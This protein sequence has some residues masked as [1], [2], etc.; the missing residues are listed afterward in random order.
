MKR[1]KHTLSHYNMRTF[2]LGELVPVQCVPV[3]PGDTAQGWNS[4]IFRLSP[5]NTP[6]MHPVDVRLHTWFV[7]NR[8]IDDGWED[9]ITGGN[10]GTGGSLPTFNMTSGKKTLMT[11]LGVP[12]VAVG[13]TLN[14]LPLYACNKII[15][16]RYLDQDAETQR[17][18]ADGSVPFCAWEKDYFTTARPWTQR[19][20]DVTLPVGDSAP[21]IGEAI[22]TGTLD[23]LVQDGA[24]GTIR[25]VTGDPAALGATSAN[26]HQLVADLANAVSPTVNDWRAAFSLQRYQEAR[27]RYGA[28]FTEYLRYLGIT[29]S[30]ARLQEPEYLGGGNARVNFSEVLQTSPNAS[31]GTTGDDGV[32]DLY[33]HGIAGI[34]TRRWRKWF[35]EHGY[36][37]TMCS[38]RPKALYVNGVHR[39]FLKTTKEDYFQKELANLGQQ[40]IY[41]QELHGG[42]TAG[43]VFGY[44]DRYDEYRYHPSSIAQDFRDT[45]NSWHMGRDLDSNPTLNADFV[46]CDP[47]GRIFQV[48]PA[49]ADSVWMSMNNHLV[50]RRMVPKRAKPRII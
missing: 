13:E 9:F 4:G 50:I 11:Y 37:I 44:Q 26:G 25:N 48:D 8:I 38:L 1:S 27:A 41:K 29:P 40:E 36:I 24:G 22:G 47:D 39:E 43:E 6:V 31:S 28:R 14:A 15:N 21:V 17:N 33:G 30:D 49:T 2:N 7:P 35:E 18:E 12:P 45:L 46:R 3:L 5:L 42:A 10:D 16:D 19:G 20:A 23:L 32:G 34:R